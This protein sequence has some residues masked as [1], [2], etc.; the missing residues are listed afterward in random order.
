M[1]KKELYDKLTGLYE[2]VDHALDSVDKLKSELRDIHMIIEDDLPSED[3]PLDADITV[4]AV[5]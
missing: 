3:N 2:K 1:D 5:E 4:E